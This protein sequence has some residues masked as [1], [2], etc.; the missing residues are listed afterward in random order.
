MPKVLKK[1]LFQD[2]LRDTERT[3]F[4]SR[5]EFA[6]A[7]NVPQGTLTGWILYNPRKLTRASA[8][9][10]WDY[11]GIRMYSVIGQVKESKKIELPR[12]KIENSTPT[13]NYKQAIQ[14]LYGKIEKLCED[15]AVCQTSIRRLN[16]EVRNVQIDKNTK[17]N[18]LH[19]L[20]FWK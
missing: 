20:K 11:Y 6:E 3:K 9:K 2:I 16:N 10:L 15:L 12:P 17:K 18:F 7:L 1:D 4:H 8:G 14:D 13:G 5:K 19:A